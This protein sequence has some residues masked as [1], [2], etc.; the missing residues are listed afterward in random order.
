MEKPN[1]LIKIRDIKNLLIKGTK[2]KYKHGDF[3]KRLLVDGSLLLTNDEFDKDILSS[4]VFSSFVGGNLRQLNNG[5]WGHAIAG[6]TERL[7]RLNF[8]YEDEYDECYIYV[9][10]YNAF[11]NNIL[12]HLESEISKE[13]DYDAYLMLVYKKISEIVKK[14]N[15]YYLE[16]YDDITNMIAQ[17]ELHKVLALLC[18]ISIFQDKVCLFFSDKYRNR[19]SDIGF[20]PF[21]SEIESTTNKANEDEIFQANP[22]PLT[23]IDFFEAALSGK[24]ELG[25]ISSIDMAFHGGSLWLYDGRKNA[26]LKKA[27]ERGVRIRIIINTSLQ[28]DTIA[29]HM[30][31]PGLL[32]TG[33]DKNAS[34]W[35]HFMAE[36]SDIVEVRIA[37][38]PL[39]RRT[40]IIKGEGGKG[41]ANVTYYSY[42]NFETSKDQRICFNSSNSAYRVYLNEFIYIWDN[43]STVYSKS[44]IENDNEIPNNTAL[45]VEKA[46][47][48]EAPLGKVTNIDIASHSALLWL[49]DTKY[50][51][52]FIKAINRGIKFRVIVN[53]ASIDESAK[54]IRQ[55]LKKYPGFDQCLMEWVERE[56]LYPDLI[57]VRVADVPLF[58]CIHIIKGENKNGWIRV[59]YYTYGNYD[60]SRDQR[61]CFNNSDDAYK[62]YLDEFEYIWRLSV[63]SEEYI[64]KMVNEESLSIP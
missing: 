39:L 40:Y 53:T 38:I 1:N 6:V 41:W 31:Q 52:N 29:S 57:E 5:K 30:R 37:Q 7:E 12:P 21:Q 54:H 9:C 27:I 64:K 46:L 48:E 18:M 17:K 26:I 4:S 61:L 16:L 63:K 22:I 62:L 44:V 49:I 25:K 10:F 8:E 32:Y 19:W 28:V 60:I 35:S 59:R 33:F 50:V 23:T 11:Q 43:V 24:S 15:T 58:H 34:D 51:D 3:A 20:F 56:R 55:P 45:M 13:S 14:E 42:G 2:V 36:H 47:S